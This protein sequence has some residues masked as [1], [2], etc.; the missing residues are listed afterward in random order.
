MITQAH[1]QEALS[2][3]YVE[4]VATRCGMICTSRNYDYGLDLSLIEVQEVDGQYLEGSNKLD[5]QLK[6]VLVDE[7]RTDHLTYDLDVRT[8][9]HLRQDVITRRLLV[10]MKMPQNEAEWTSQDDT[11]L[12]LRH[13]AF[14]MSLASHPPTENRRSV[15]LRI[16]R[17]NLFSVTGL[18]EIM[19]KIREGEAL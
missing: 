17:A 13:G 3:A 5:L 16:P 9:E 15:R 4:I 2:R 10:V 12:E 6:S 19:R 8:Y 7:Q 18:M 1:R 14:W 11:H